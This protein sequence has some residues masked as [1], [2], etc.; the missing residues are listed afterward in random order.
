MKYAELQWN[1]ESKEWVCVRCFKASDHLNREDAV[2]AHLS[3]Q[4]ARQ[5]RELREL[6][7]GKEFFGREIQQFATTL[8]LYRVDLMV[9]PLNTAQHLTQ[10]LNQRNFSPC[11][12]KNGYIFL[13]SAN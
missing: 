11:A 1:P 2:G 9:A 10:E 5:R 13:C 8:P 7:S 12:E 4:E 6:V 3:P